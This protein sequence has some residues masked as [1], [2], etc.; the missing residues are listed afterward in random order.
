MESIISVPPGVTTRAILAMMFCI[1]SAQ[2]TAD[3][4]VGSTWPASSIQQV[5]E[6]PAKPMTLPRWV[7][8]SAMRASWM[9]LR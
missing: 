4:A 5:M 6:S 7:C 8:N 2:A 9:G 1:A 3:P